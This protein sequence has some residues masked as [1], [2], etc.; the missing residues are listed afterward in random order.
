MGSAIVTATSGSLKAHCTIEVGEYDGYTDI[1]VNPVSLTMKVGESESLDLTVKPENIPAN[2]VKW[3]TSN[4]RV[5]T[6]ENGKVTAIGYGKAKITA[7]SASITATCEVEVN[8]PVRNYK[9]IWSDEF[10]LPDI[11]TSKWNFETG[12][13]DSGTR[14][15]NIIP[16]AGIIHT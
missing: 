5:A 12:G 15:N 9:L 16:T 8:E 14:K 2:Y 4:E 13:P 7:S 3:E 6:V 11:D 10:D 1:T